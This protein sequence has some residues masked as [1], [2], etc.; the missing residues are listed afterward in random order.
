MDTSLIFS[1]SKNSRATETLSSLRCLSMGRAWNFLNIL[2]WLRTSSKEMRFRPSLRS[3]RRS[4]ICLPTHLRCSLHQRVK[5]FFWIFFHGAS[6]DR[7]IWAAVTLLMKSLI[8][9]C[10]QI[11][12]AWAFPTE[13]S[14]YQCLGAIWAFLKIC[15]KFFL[16]FYSNQWHWSYSAPGDPSLCDSSKQ[17]VSSLSSPPTLWLQQQLCNYLSVWRM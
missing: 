3:N 2:L 5:V 8:S 4:F 16:F 13:E 17:E 15:W 12:L 6:S 7:L 9:L 10:S 1:R 14:L 11:P